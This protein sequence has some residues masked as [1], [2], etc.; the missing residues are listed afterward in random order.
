[1]HADSYTVDRKRSDLKENVQGELESSHWRGQE[2]VGVGLRARTADCHH[3][4]LVL[5]PD[6]D[7]VAD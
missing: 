5:G 1:M 3:G 4:G 7:T 6:L 2:R